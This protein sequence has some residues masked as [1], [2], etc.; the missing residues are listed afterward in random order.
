MDK[1]KKILDSKPV[2]FK[3][4]NPEVC[5]PHCGAKDNGSGRHVHVGH[6]DKCHQESNY[7]ISYRPM[8]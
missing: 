7:A 2:E 3:M 5:G 8:H 1:S 4:L 6:C